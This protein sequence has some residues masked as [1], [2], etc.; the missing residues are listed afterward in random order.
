[1]DATTALEESNQ[2]LIGLIAGL[3]P[4]DRETRTPCD[5][6]NVHE[7]VEHIC[8]GTH[9]IA[10]G[11][12]GQAPPEEMPDFMAEGPANAWAEAYNHLTS[13]ATPEVLTALHQMPFGEVPGEAAVS[14]IVADQV[15]HA[16][17]LAQATGQEFAP[18][19]E[20]AQFALTTWQP[21]VPAEGRAGGSFKAA[22]D[23]SDGAPALDRLVAYTGRQP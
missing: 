23:I 1:M 3:T 12:A 18:S 11:L 19:E 10:G 15:T 7:L 8:S 20:L 2:L 14:V 21:L 17:D 13:V 4:D 9:G 16:W 5:E 6:W 22:I